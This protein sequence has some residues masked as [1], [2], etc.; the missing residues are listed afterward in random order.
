MHQNAF[1]R[2][3]TCHG[4]GVLVHDGGA[5][6]LLALHKDGWT[7]LSGKSEGKETLVKRPFANAAK[8][9]CLP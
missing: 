9:R 4:A 6:V 5:R 2:H 7:T 3:G 1:T 8:R